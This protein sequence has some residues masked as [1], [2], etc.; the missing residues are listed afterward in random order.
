VALSVG[1]TG[2]FISGDSLS[3]NKSIPIK[4]EAPLKPRASPKGMYIR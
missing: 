2:A 4:A 3:A 1:P